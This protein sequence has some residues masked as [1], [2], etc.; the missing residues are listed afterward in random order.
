MNTL[1]D[2]FIKVGPTL[3]QTLDLKWTD[4]EKS[5]SNINHKFYVIP[6]PGWT[7]NIFMKIA[8]I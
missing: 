6:L 8:V 2:Q 3:L 5:S 7:E 1:N 4:L